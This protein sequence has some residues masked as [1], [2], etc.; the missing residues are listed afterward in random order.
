M[1]GKT[2]LALPIFGPA[3]PGVPVTAAGSIANAAESKD[4][5]REDRLSALRAC[6]LEAKSCRACELAAR[7]N[8]VVFG[9][10][11]PDADIMFVGEGPGAE[12]DAQGRPF[13]G[14]AGQLLDRILAASGLKREEVYISNVVKCRPPGNRIPTPEEAK[15]CSKFLAEQIRLIQ[16]SIIVALGATAAKALV[17]PEARI[18]KIRGNWFLKDGVWIMPTFHPAALLRDPSKK[19]PVWE[20]MKN[21]LAKAAELGIPV[22]GL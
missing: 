14:A 4:L 19:R 17:D 3:A 1:S 22:R 5:S 21:V 10:G 8:S 6:E 7:R 11:N 9:E 16:P 2:Q 20:D 13:V 12:E 15:S 18:T